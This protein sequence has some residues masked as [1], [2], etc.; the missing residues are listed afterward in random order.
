[1]IKAIETR[2][3]GCNFRS[4]LEARWAV[5][6]DALGIKWE[7]EKEGYVVGNRTPY[8]PD[9]YLPDLRTWVE[10][11]GAVSL[12]DYQLM[13]DAVDW[14]AGLPGTHE[15]YGKYGGLLL[16]G[17]LPFVSRGANFLPVHPILQHYH[18]GHVCSIVFLKFKFMLSKWPDTCFDSTWGDSGGYYDE[19]KSHV[20]QLFDGGRRWI[21]P[22]RQSDIDPVIRAYTLARSARFEHGQKGDRQ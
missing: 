17:P 13:A 3:K 14:G 18:G 19:W 1:M 9:F 4:R 8:L 7:Y 6:F 10:V 11:K 21:C 5:F 22:S 2:Y 15:C 12:L 20:S 16:L